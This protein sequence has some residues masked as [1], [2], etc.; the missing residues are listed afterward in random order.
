MG[1]LEHFAPYGWLI[2]AT[3]NPRRKDHAM[4]VQPPHT[5]VVT[6]AYHPDEDVDDRDYTIVCAGVT[7]A[8]RRWEDCTVADCTVT[9][10]YQHSARDAL[11]HG[12]RHNH[13]DGVWMTPTDRGMYVGHDGVPEAADHL[14]LTAGV[15]PVDVDYIGD[16]DVHLA[17]VEPAVTR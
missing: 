16:G 15:Y 3:C 10:E 17:V 6:G 5:L 1:D 12:Q 2:V 7:D 13:I 14:D 4:T 9:A 8:C 11:G